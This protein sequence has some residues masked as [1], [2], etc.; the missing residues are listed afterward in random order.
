M[1]ISRI[2]KLVTFSYLWTVTK[3]ILIL[4]QIDSNLDVILK[5]D[6]LSHSR[7]H[8]YSFS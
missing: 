3:Q 1:K 8:T 6:L 7:I 4:L 5:I 2:L